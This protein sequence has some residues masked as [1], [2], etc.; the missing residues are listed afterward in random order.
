M[1]KWEEDLA[2]VQA[3]Y[4]DVVRFRRMGFEEWKK[5]LDAHPEDRGLHHINLP[6]GGHLS[7]S[8]EST[9]RFFN[10]TKR[11]IAITPNNADLDRTTLNH[12]IRRD[13]VETF[14]RHER[15]IER[16]AV[17]KML[18][19]SVK[20][21]RRKHRA[22]T[23]YL[24][25]TLVGDHQ[26]Y[27]FRLGPV[28]F[29]HESKFFNDF[30]GSIEA[31]HRQTSTERREKAEAKLAAGELH[32]LMSRE[33]WEALDRQM[34]DWIGEYYKPYKWIAEVTVPPCDDKISRTRAELTAQAAL[35]VLKLFALGWYHG[36]RV[37]LGRDYGI[38]D[39]V[40]HIVRHEDAQFA[41]TWSRGAYWAFVDDGWFEDLETT[42]AG[43]LNAAAQIIEVYLSPMKPFQI[44]TRWLDA[45]NW[46]GQAV[47][48][49]LPAVKIVKYVA[50]L[51][52]LTI[53]EE[54]E[55]D[56]DRGLTNAVTRRAA[57]FAAG[58]DVEARNRRREEARE[59][60]KLRS[61]LMHGQRS[62]I[63]KEQLVSDEH[64]SLMVK[65]D[66]LTRHVL[67]DALA[68]Y[69]NLVM[70]GKKDDHDLEEHLRALEAASNATD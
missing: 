2:D 12:A 63:S 9:R 39:K 20:A 17:D 6:E 55:T 54:T 28:R 30:W 10:L 35:D 24:P 70:S 22:I 32:E 46:Y 66:D 4:D 69:A 65:A 33:E 23:H 16:S 68:E 27:E 59:M 19:R 52:R 1:S 15:A 45:L 47:A 11:L 38:I 13:F 61:K 36:D 53:T 58:T 14:L 40:A 51:E 50:A 43:H 5:H 56:E 7:I 21:V 37:R 26:P 25:C 41:V 29:I 48:E 62:P 64:R 44:A 57:L 49:Q 8:A 34:L 3:I 42:M 18:A 67:I 31:Q 60:Y